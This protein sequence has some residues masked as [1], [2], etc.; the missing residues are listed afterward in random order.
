MPQDL[1]QGVLRAGT[2]AVRDIRAQPPFHLDRIYVIGPSVLFD[3]F[4]R[5]ENLALAFG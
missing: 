4:N 1:V 5:A 3:F 2:V